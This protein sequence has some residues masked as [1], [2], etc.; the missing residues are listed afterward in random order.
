MII[1]Q[2][3][4]YYIRNFVMENNIVVFLKGHNELPPNELHTLGRNMINVSYNGYLLIFG[5]MGLHCCT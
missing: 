1:T 2:D 5:C 3:L 4:C